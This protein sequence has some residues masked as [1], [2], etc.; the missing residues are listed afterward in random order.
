[1]KAKET[2]PK[3]SDAGANV[4]PSSR[5]TTRGAIGLAPTPRDRFYSR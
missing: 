3:L 1:M 4:S 5:V 2:R